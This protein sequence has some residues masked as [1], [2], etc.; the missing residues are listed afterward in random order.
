LGEIAP[1]ARSAEWYRLSAMA[2]RDLAELQGGPNSNL[3]DRDKRGASLR[4][5]LEEWNR[6]RRLAPQDHRLQLGQLTTEFSL[7][8]HEKVAIDWVAME[9]RYL[10]LARSHPRDYESL[11]AVGSFYF[12]RGAKATKEA[13]T[14]D[15]Q[16]SL[17]WFQRASAMNAS[18]P[19]SKRDQALLHK[20][21]ANNVAQIEQEHH[22]REAVRLD[23]E[24]VAMD[25]SHAAAR[26]DLAFSINALADVLRR[27]N[28][29][30][31]ALEN[32]TEAYNIR[33]Q[34]AAADPKNALAVRSLSYPSGWGITMSIRLGRWEAL[35]AWMSE[36]RWQQN[37]LSLAPPAQQSA[38]E[39]ALQ[40]LEGNATEAC[41]KLRNS[42]WLTDERSDLSQRCASN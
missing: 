2:Y 4:K 27:L 6:A 37:T 36:L 11:R 1:G 10:K 30:A 3:G 29:G 22:A 21:L 15:Y 26:L 16:A 41:R 12:L 19:E 17:L 18:R 24:R 33:K 8:L 42:G 40:V 25:P 7:N 34:I 38:A 28:Q 9:K 14:A 39:L 20:Y 35:R 32:Y 13:R 23:R 31:A 5:S